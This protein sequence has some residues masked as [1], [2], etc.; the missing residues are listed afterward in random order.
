MIE[1]MGQPA[2]RFKLVA[3]V[4]LLLLAALFIGGHVIPALQT[5]NTP[6][7]ACQLLGGHWSIWSGW[8]CG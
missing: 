1:N 4:A 2:P 3:I 7:A 6:P 8:N 5:Q